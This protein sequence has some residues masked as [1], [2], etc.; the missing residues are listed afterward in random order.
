MPTLLADI[1][2][3][4]LARNCISELSFSPARIEKQAGLFPD[5]RKTILQKVLFSLGGLRLYKKNQ[6][7]FLAVPFFASERWDKGSE[8]DFTVRFRCHPVSGEL[9]CGFLDGYG[10]LERVLRREDRIAPLLGNQPPLMLWRPLWYELQGVEQAVLLGMEKAIQWNQQC[11]NLNGVF[12]ESLDRLF[13][14][15]AG[16]KWP[17][18]R[19]MGFLSRLTRKL[20][21][22]GSL[23]FLSGDEF[24]AFGDNE[25]TAQLLWKVA[26]S[27]FPG[28][29]FAEYRNGVFQLLQR[30]RGD[31]LAHKA[32]VQELIPDTGKACLSHIDEK[33]SAINKVSQDTPLENQYWVVGGNILLSFR[34]LY[35]EWI[36]RKEFRVSGAL[37]SGQIPESLL[38][39]I[40]AVNASTKFWEDGFRLFCQKL[41][42]HRQNKTGIER[43]AGFSVLLERVYDKISEKI[44]IILSVYSYL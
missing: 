35:L 30:L 14:F 11:F 33:I 43:Q 37:D 17:F 44:D 20:S 2:S 39:L 13:S 27:R 26:P 40:P 18:E 6:T 7:D 31:N 29:E 8:E 38:S 5:R 9:L 25:P 15:E 10:E 12:G 28:D 4:F 3:H 34:E 41:C 1:Q 19:K 22:H 32:W 24:L 42:D 21:D 16:K 36:L 23:R